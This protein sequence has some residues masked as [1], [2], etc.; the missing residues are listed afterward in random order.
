MGEVFNDYSTLVFT[1]EKDMDAGKIREEYVDILGHVNIQ[2]E[3]LDVLKNIKEIMKTID[4]DRAVDLVCM[5]FNKA[6]ENV[7][8]GKLVQKIKSHGIHGEL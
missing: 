7:P 4:E 5:S 3:L 6:F 1:K 8:H 2:K